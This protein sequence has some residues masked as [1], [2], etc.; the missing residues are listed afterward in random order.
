MKKVFS[1]KGL[2]T[3]V[4]LPQIFSITYVSISIGISNIATVILPLS[5]ISLSCLYFAVYAYKKGEEE[6]ISPKMFLV[7]SIIYACLILYAAANTA[8]ITHMK[9]YVSPRL[10]F[11]LTSMVSV[12]YGIIGFCDSTMS[13]G[14]T[15]KVSKH[16]LGL[17]A[18]PLIWFL[19][20][21]FLGG[22]NTNTTIMTIIVALCYIVLFFLT[23]FLFLWKRDRAPLAVDTEP[24]EKYY[25]AAVII[26]IVL[27]FFGLAL[28][29]SFTGGINGGISA[30]VFGDF[31]HPLFLII[32]LVNGSLLLVP[33]VKDSRLRLLLFYLKSAGYTYILYFF[34][35][36]IPILPVGVWGITVFGLGLLV[37]APAMVTI[38]QG[39]HLIKE[40]IILI[41][42]WSK[43]IVLGVFLFGI[44]TI[45]LFMGITIY[46][47]KANF[48]FAVEYLE[49]KDADKV[50]PV[51]LSRLQRTINNINSN[52]LLVRGDFGFSM[53]NT[54][55]LSNIYSSYVLDKKIISKENVIRLE[56]LFFDKGH[57]MEEL[58]LS[59]PSI[60]SSSVR[61]LEADS[62]TSFDE[63]LGVYKSWVNLKLQNFSSE[64]N[65][66]YKTEF[67]L[68][69][70]AYITDY[71]LNVLGTKKE[72]ILTDRRAALF[73]YQKIVNTR[74]DPGLL[75][76]IG[77]NTLELRVFPFGANEIRET[78]FEILHSKKFTLELDGKAISLEGDD[79]QKEI[80]TNG[81][82]LLTSE[83]KTQLPSV[84]RKAKYYF[85]I[86]NSKNSAVDWHIS[87]IKE[88]TELN[89]ITTADVIFASHILQKCALSEL[90]LI[91]YKSERGFNFNL[92]VR[93]ILSKE[94]KNNFPIIIAVSDNLPS[95]VMPYDAFTLSKSFPES[96]FYYSLNHNLTLKPYSF[97][98]NKGENSIDKPVVMPILDYKGVYVLDNDENELVI[99]DG[100][101]NTFKSANN[102]YENALQIH[103]LLSSGNTDS[104][105]LLRA[106][107]RARI[108][109]PQN[110]F[111]VLETQEQER[112]LLD[113][114]EKLLS[115]NE[116]SPTVTL[117]EPSL[118]SCIVILLVIVFI[119]KR[120]KLTKTN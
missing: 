23:K 101:N 1:P 57:N 52:I 21:N 92:A 38:F 81:A 109:T 82:V 113:L 99:T 115:S 40:G 43:G 26:G 112:E 41:K 54:P 55:I 53:T 65:G 48:K 85:V 27:P 56:N 68:P 114:Q 120:K 79:K 73:M 100:F 34:I 116:T 119:S 106:S 24:S 105:D 67:K 97:E 36:F 78:G 94:D 50:N 95:A 11:I 35:V 25:T 45:P 33:R 107:F 7:I 84:V 29:Q 98:A 91:K 88:Y 64:G 77:K 8:E 61:I 32:A 16:T 60:V 15:F 71:Y 4:V 47:D 39:Y 108:L 63:N 69:E 14:N 46:G 103:T 18:I 9:G 13:Q 19:A 110:A 51:N 10:I 83:Q 58:S 20:G 76:Y 2:W 42:T 62:I 31:S 104:L 90:S 6:R 96:P 118:I 80:M 74:R 89:N 70:G 5:I 17:I 111:I 87:Q 72:G 75:H 59:D 66:E 117:D 30:G 93:D 102:Q 28:N 37:F 86:D 12:L 49:T 3:L 44:L 22:V